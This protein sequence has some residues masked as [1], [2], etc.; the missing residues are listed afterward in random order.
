MSPLDDLPE[1]TRDQPL[2]Y[3]S[4]QG[5]G[6]SG[7]WPKWVR[8]VGLAVVAAVLA[9]VAGSWAAWSQR[10]WQAQ[11]QV[12]PI[13]GVIAQS[14]MASEGVATNAARNRALQLTP[15][16]R[17]LLGHRAYDEAP[18]DD[19]V[20]LAINRDIRLRTSAAEQFDAM[21]RAARRDGVQI[22]PLSGFRSHSEQEA[23]FFGVRAAR[24][25]DAQT[26]AEVSAPPGYSEHHTGYAIDVG[27]GNQTSTHLD[28]AFEDTNAYRWMDANA[29]RYG[30]EL[31]FPRNN[32]Q[33]VAFEP[34]HWR[35]TGD[36]DSLETFYQE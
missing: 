34:W 7:T 4:P 24:G 12:Q 33:Q 28:Q 18:E 10:G 3:R 2:G 25:Q 31:S 15:T 1:A 14:G 17:T 19:L 20:S 30:F 23:I 6:T 11:P 9:L 35:F 32:F 26:R 13:Q 29:N 8:W 5:W 22:I 21:V 36:R 27:D 16:S